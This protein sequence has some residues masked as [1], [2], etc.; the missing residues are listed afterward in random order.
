MARL[1]LFAEGRTEQT[2]ANAVLSPHLAD[3]GVYL[4]RSVLI[5]HSHKNQELIDD[6][7]DT[8]PSRR[9]ITELPRYEAD[10]VTVGVQAAEQIGLPAIRSKCPHFSG[11]LTRLQA[12][13]AR[14]GG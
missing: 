9:I 6:G 11:W 12:L 3:H 5:A 1:Y 4:H 13:D 7:R 2:F 10:K 8:A 14:S